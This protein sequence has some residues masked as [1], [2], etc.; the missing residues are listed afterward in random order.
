MNDKSMIIIGAGIAGLSAGCY[1][2]MNGFKS[3]IFEMHTQP[4]GLCTSWKRKD[5]TIDGCIHWLVGSSPKSSFNRYWQEVGLSKGRKFIDPDIY[6]TFESRDGTTLTF[7]ADPDRLEKHLIELA[8]EDTASIKEFTDGVRFCLRMDPPSGDE[9]GIA[10]FMANALFAIK[11][12]PGMGRFQKYLKTTTTDYVR[13]LKN[14]LLQEAFTEIWLPEFSIFFMM[15]T[16]AYI[17]QKNAGYPIGG[18]SPMAE[19]VERRYLSLG[20]QIHYHSRVQKILVEKNRAV[21]I[22]LEDGSEYRADQVVSAAD[23]HATIF[24][25]LEGKYIDD[26]IRGYYKNYKIFPPLIFIG[27]GVRRT[28]EEIPVTVSGLSIPLPHP[29]EIGDRTHHRMSVQIYNQDPTMAP[30]GKTVL[31]VMFPSDYVY[32]KGLAS[33]PASYQEKKD[34]IAREVVSQLDRRFPGL[35]GQVDMVDV[36]TPMTFERYTGNWQ[37]SFEGWMMTPE[38]G[39]KRMSKTLPGLENFYMVGQWVQPGGGLPSGVQT[40]REVLQMICKKEKVK[41]TTTLD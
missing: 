33:D 38:I 24:D 28:F 20:G 6:A 31:T 21:G 32:W 39:M 8:P 3:Q 35:A 14:P 13:R 9:K 41:F 4:G 5:Y 23:G 16:I 36:A 12:I 40:A 30:S 18:S 2:Q 1:A 27:L 25:M 26:T 34:Q 11:M 7:Y 15:F 10:M 37:G 17:H 19:A 22:R 29:V